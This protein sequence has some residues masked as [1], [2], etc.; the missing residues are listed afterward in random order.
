MMKPPPKRFCFVSCETLSLYWSFAIIEVISQ[1]GRLPYF[2]NFAMGKNT[3]LAEILAPY[4]EEKLWVALNPE[5]TQV[6]GKGKHLQ[7]ALQGARKN[8]IENPVV[9]KAIPDYANFI[10]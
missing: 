4:T 2:Y 1:K 10:L 9:I 7:E 3:N 5:R 8:N 6:V